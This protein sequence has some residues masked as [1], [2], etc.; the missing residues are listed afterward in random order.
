MQG[1][2]FGY[3]RG[4]EHKCNDLY[5]TPMPPNISEKVPYKKK[6]PDNE[7][8]YPILGMLLAIPYPNMPSSTFLDP[9]KASG[10]LQGKEA[11]GRC[12]C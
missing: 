6:H 5:K 7:I 11:G 9:F 1:E 2:C 12:K 4:S 8:S 10:K 3:K